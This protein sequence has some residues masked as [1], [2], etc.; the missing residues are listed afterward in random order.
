MSCNQNCDQGRNCTC[1]KDRNL[2]WD[3]MEGAVTLAVIV[4]IVIGMCFVFG[5]I[6]YRT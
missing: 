2:F 1:L 5:Y 4:G 3:V 6:W